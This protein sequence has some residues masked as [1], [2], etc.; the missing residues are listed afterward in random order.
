MVLTGAAIYHRYYHALYT[1]WLGPLL[2][3]TVD[4]S[5]NCEDIL[6]N[7]LVS[8][9]TRQPPIKVSQ[10][11]QYKS[12][13]LSA[14]TR[15]VAFFF[16]FTC[17]FIYRALNHAHF[18]NA[19]VFIGFIFFFFLSFAVSVRSRSPWNDPDHFL[20]R[21]TCLNTFVALFG[22]MPLIRSAVRFDPVLFKDPVSNLRKKYRQME[23]VNN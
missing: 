12:S 23:L 19:H 3:K 9:V 15:S 21:Q 17:F 18:P 6:I 22:Y 10:R 8:H 13:N 1:D 2:H 11:K 16:F 20:Q 14:V 5:H 7:F 4:Q